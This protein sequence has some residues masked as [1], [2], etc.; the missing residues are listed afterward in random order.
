MEFSPVRVAALLN[1]NYLNPSSKRATEGDKLFASK[2]IAI[3][4]RCQ[5]DKKFLESVHQVLSE[6]DDSEY[7]YFDEFEEHE[8]P[9]DINVYP[10]KEDDDWFDSVALTN[11]P[12][13]N[14]QLDPQLHEGVLFHG[15]LFPI[16]Q[17]ERAL[18]FYRSGKIQAGKTK[19]SRKFEEMT[20]DFYSMFKS[21]Y[22]ID[23][24]I[25]NILTGLI[26][27]FRLRDYEKNGH[28]NLIKRRAAL[29]IIDNKT[30]EQFD[31]KFG[32]VDIHDNDIKKWGM[33]VYWSL[34]TN[35]EFKASDRWVQYWKQ[36][37]RIVSR[38]V[39]NWVKKKTD[40]QVTIFKFTFM[41]LILI[42]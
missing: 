13:I 11:T 14:V 9:Y 38:K 37:H 35:F 22:D 10:A 15:K 21:N 23:T 29:A 3:M 7:C 28:S 4:E 16:E 31:E 20:H 19:G 8:D 30:F 6:L 2:L 17:V 25:L 18:A 5:R 41:I 24:Y 33:K 32:K 40:R 27:K 12:T 39:T 1:D 26:K 42:D 36:K 34:E